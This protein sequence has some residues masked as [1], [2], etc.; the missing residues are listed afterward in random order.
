MLDL[1]FGKLSIVVNPVQP[2]EE[3][4]DLTGTETAIQQPDRRS[5]PNHMRRI[6]LE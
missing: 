5:E 2:T 3:I 4:D 1:L 6:R